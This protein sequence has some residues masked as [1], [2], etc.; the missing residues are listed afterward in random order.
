MQG[1]NLIRLGLKEDGL[2]PLNVEEIRIA[3]NVGANLFVRH[4]HV[5][6]KAITRY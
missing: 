2:L 6:R 3:V 5:S 1:D 4:Q